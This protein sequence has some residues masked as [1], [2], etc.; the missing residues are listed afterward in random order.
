MKGAAQFLA[1][2]LPQEACVIWPGAKTPEGYG[3]LWNDG[4]VVAAHRLSHHLH[5]GLVAD[6]DFVCHRCDTPA[7]VNPA[8]LFIGSHADNMAD[9]AAKGRAFA[10][11]RAVTECPSGHP[12]STE[13]TYNHGGTRHCR[14]CV[15]ARSREYQRRR[16]QARAV[17]AQEQ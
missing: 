15:R 3:R 11:G 4:K 16:R 6:G 2:L 1:E 5:V 14:E 13:N 10:R 7:C 12:Y 9:M 17:L 8:H